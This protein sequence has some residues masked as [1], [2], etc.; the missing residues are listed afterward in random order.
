MEHILDILTDWYQTNRLLYAITTVLTM[1]VL[2]TT[3]A[4]IVQ[5]GTNGTVLDKGAVEE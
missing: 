5:W 2:G 4:L 3:F 1:G